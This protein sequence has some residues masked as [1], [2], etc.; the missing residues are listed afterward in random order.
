MRAVLFWGVLVFNSSVH[1]EIL[2]CKEM[3]SEE[4]Q[5][6]AGG[7]GSNLPPIEVAAGEL[8][9]EQ[10]FLLMAK[11]VIRQSFKVSS[12]GFISLNLSPRNEM[13]F[14]AEVIFSIGPARYR[15]TIYF[16]IREQTGHFVIVYGVLKKDL[17]RILTRQITSENKFESRQLTTEYELVFMD[18]KGRAV[19]IGKYL[20]LDP[21]EDEVRGFIYPVRLKPNETL[22]NQFQFGDLKSTW[23]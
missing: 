15:D 4:V 3:F 5:A 18:A 16:Y 11:N 23:D 19:F 6:L 17:R 2:H 10:D 8:P 20:R 1:A 21:L 7:S 9:S 12:V 13:T 22:E 14:S